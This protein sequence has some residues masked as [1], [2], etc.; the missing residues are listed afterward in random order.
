[1]RKIIMCPSHISHIVCTI[2]K[3]N[4][5]QNK[6][7]SAAS[8]NYIPCFSDFFSMNSFLYNPPDDFHTC[9]KCQKMKK[10]NRSQPIQHPASGNAEQSD[11]QRQ[12]SGDR[13]FFPDPQQS[14]KTNNNMIKIN[15]QRSPDQCRKQ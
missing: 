8:V 7:N 6:T 14:K 3:D 13:C 12:N 15:S 10:H 5:K 9:R 11:R 4:C 2:S 1:N